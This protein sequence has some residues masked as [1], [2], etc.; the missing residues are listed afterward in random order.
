MPFGLEGVLL[1]VFLLTSFRC[2]GVTS[3]CVASCT[4]NSTVSRLRLKGA[5]LTLVPVLL[6]EIVKGERGS[7]IKHRR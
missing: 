7:G 1:I 6:S 3:A 2:R 5:S 4:S